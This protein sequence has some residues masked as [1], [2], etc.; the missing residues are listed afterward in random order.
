MAPLQ[1]EHR[2][3]TAAVAHPGHRRVAGCG[4]FGVNGAQD[5]RQQVHIAD[6]EEKD[7]WPREGPLHRGSDGV[8][9][10]ERLIPGGVIAG[11]TGGDASRRRSSRGRSRP[12]KRTMPAA[13]PHD[14]SEAVRGSGGFPP[15]RSS[16]PLSTPTNGTKL[17]RRAARWMPRSRR[18]LS[19]VTAMRGYFACS[20]QPKTSSTTPGMSS[21][22]N[23][24][25]A[26]D[27]EFLQFNDL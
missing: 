12:M 20:R 8:F 3:E 13:G 9:V 18:A 22:V 23:S 16:T 26:S 7:A 11:D 14:R 10:F 24:R 4:E 2:G 15:W 6:R 21:H 25:P 17:C 5:S 27:S 19:P 1:A